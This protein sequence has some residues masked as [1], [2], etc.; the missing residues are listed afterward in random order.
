MCV[1]L[2]A[3]CSFKSFYY[4]Y[5]IFFKT[6]YSVQSIY[7]VD[8]PWP[9][10]WPM[11]KTR[12]PKCTE[13]RV[14][15]TQTSVHRHWHR[16]GTTVAQPE[17]AAQSPPVRREDGVQQ[18]YQTQSKHGIPH[19]KHAQRSPH[20]RAR[21]KYAHVHRSPQS[22]RPEHGVLYMLFVWYRGQKNPGFGSFAVVSQ[23]V[24]WLAAR[25]A[26]DMAS[27]K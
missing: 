12:S 9:W 5:S 7:R 16:T 13:C 14:Q 2:I 11:A 1:F 17:Y 24:I 18:H 15:N 4:L 26:G 21:N 10:P 20:G 19:P 8:T 25:L 3:C 23:S 27:A 6:Q 22:T